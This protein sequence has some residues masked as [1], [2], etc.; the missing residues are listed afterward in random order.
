[1]WKVAGR[2]RQTCQAG[3]RTGTGRA[4]VVLLAP[5]LIPGGF[6][7][8]AGPQGRCPENQHNPR[9]GTEASRDFCFGS[10]SRT[11][12]LGAWQPGRAE[13]EER[14]NAQAAAHLL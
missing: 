13:G 7:L 10:G 8:P 9:E 14:E 3:A 6:K 2:Q 4:I 12:C 5:L 1:M 11:Q